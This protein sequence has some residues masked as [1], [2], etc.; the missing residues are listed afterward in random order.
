MR[1]DFALRFVDA[2]LAL[3]LSSLKAVSRRA[4]EKVPEA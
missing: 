4:V 3:D 1:R 2:M